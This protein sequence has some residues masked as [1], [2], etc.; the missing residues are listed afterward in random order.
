[1]L[2]ILWAIGVL[3]LAYTHPNSTYV[4]NISICKEPTSNLSALLVCYSQLMLASDPMGISLHLLFGGNLVN[5]PVT[6]VMI[7]SLVTFIRSLNTR[8]SCSAMTKNL[9]DFSTSIN[10]CVLGLSGAE[11]IEQPDAKRKATFNGLLAGQRVFLS[12]S[13]I[14]WPPIPAAH[15]MVPLGISAFLRTVTMPERI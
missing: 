2:V 9:S 14:S 12:F 5:G 7:S 6:A 3:I 10:C 4:L 8:T 11:H 1:M 15:K 13:T